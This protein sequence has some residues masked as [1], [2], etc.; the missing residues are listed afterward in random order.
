MKFDVVGGDVIT[1]LN[2]GG[3]VVNVGG[4][5]LVASAFDS[6]KEVLLYIHILKSWRALAVDP[7]HYCV[8]TILNKYG[9]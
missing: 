2:V 6:T 9:N 7:Y 5:K 3:T 1:I 8:K 4:Q